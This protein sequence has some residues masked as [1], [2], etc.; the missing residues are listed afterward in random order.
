MKK[1]SNVFY[2]I[3][4]VLN[5]L[6]IVFYILGIIGLAVVYSNHDLIKQISTEL[7]RGEAFVKDALIVYLI[8]LSIVTVIEIV[9]S[10]F[11]LRAKKNLKAGNGKIG[12]HILLLILGILGTNLFY[13]LGVIFGMVAASGDNSVI[14]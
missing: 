8:F 2:S 10:L 4:F 5:I 13:L 7:N 11:V 14:E 6:G 12:T 3:G 1:A 9:I